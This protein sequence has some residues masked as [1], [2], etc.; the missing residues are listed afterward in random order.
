MIPEEALR[1]PEEGDDTEMRLVPPIIC[2]DD[3]DE[4]EEE[5][6]PALDPVVVPG[7]RP[8]EGRRLFFFDDD[9][10]DV[11][12]TADKRLSIII[13]PMKHVTSVWCS[14]M[15][16]TQARRRG[17]AP[18]MSAVSSIDAAFSTVTLPSRCLWH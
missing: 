5:V 14:V 12:D 4:E 10:A 9:D 8:G 6:A 18:Y 2:I 7:L 3:D 16:F 11:V 13:E 17:R 15:N 1:L